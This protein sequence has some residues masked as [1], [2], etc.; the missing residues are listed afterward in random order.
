MTSFSFGQTNFDVMNPDA[1]L[2]DSLVFDKIKQYQKDLFN[3]K[4][5]NE[6]TLQFSSKIFNASFILG[7]NKNLSDTLSC[8]YTTIGLYT[9]TVLDDVGNR[10]IVEY[11]DSSYIGHPRLRLFFLC[12]LIGRKSDCINNNKLEFIYNPFGET[13]LKTI[14]NTVDAITYDE[15]PSCTPYR[16]N[17]YDRISTFS[18]IFKI[19]TYE[20]MSEIIFND[21]ISN[22]TLKNKI[23]KS[24]GIS[25]DFTRN[26]KEILTTI[27]LSE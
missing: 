9:N 21:I 24:I 16:Y 3:N 27:I 19:N 10:Q 22:K 2:L 23:S 17:K 12:G 18:N 20:E 13:S 25:C 5:T 15:C 14:I 8:E 26:R 4:I 1:E 7:D 11:L 6:F